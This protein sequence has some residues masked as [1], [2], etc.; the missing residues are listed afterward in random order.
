MKN[1][2]FVY[3]MVLPAV[4]FAGCA[5]P[6]TPAPQI[7]PQHVRKIFVKPFVNSTIQYGLEDK[8]TLA[9]TNGLIN[10]GRFTVVNNEADADGMLVGEISK[11][12][13]QPLTYDANMVTLQYK[14]WILVNIYFVDRVKN[15]TL[16]SEPNMQGTLTYY[17][18]TQPGGV[19]E[20]Q[21]R[22]TIWN[23][24]SADI[25][26]RTVNGFGAVTGISEKKVPGNQ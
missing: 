3:A 9:V 24:M 15:V 23:N 17:D 20:E 12:V 7:L 14:L 10:E 16:W 13:L 11:Y 18:L 19:S 1:K 25:V 22:E 2:F 5:G 4:I 26:N 8:L 21:A 6:Y